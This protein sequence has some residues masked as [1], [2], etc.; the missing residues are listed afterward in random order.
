MHLGEIFSH[1]D[2]QME[3]L[4][5]IIIESLFS[6]GHDHLVSHIL[7]NPASQGCFSSKVVD[8]LFVRTSDKSLTTLSNRLM[9]Q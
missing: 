3:E 9:G 2:T 7:V 5:A 6:S 4:S 1:V 8:N